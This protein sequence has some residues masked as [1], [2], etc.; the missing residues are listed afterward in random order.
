LP[1][2]ALACPA[3]WRTKDRSF[4]FYTIYDGKVAVA[5]DSFSMHLMDDWSDRDGWIYS[6]LEPLE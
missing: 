4:Y 6:S 5:A 1:S 2:I 3:L